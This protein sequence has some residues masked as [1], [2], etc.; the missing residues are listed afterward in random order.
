[1]RRS[2]R[3]CRNC[4]KPLYKFS[5]PDKY[6]CDNKCWSKDYAYRRK[7]GRRTVKSFKRRIQG[8]GR[9]SKTEADRGERQAFKVVVREI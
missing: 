2:K 4:N 3:R 8:N 9:S 1:M 5:R 7:N 6:Y